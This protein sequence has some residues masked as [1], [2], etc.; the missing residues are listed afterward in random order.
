MCNTDKVI[1][2]SNQTTFIQ[3]TSHINKTNR[4]HKH[5]HSFQTEDNTVTATALIPG[6]NQENR[7]VMGFRI[8]GNTTG[9][10]LI[11]ATDVATGEALHNKTARS[12]K[13]IDREHETPL[14]CDTRPIDT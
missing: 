10:K 3:K 12:S 2:K 14:N 8:I 7:A 11:N 5:T 9:I 6:T 13:V 1:P 4:Q